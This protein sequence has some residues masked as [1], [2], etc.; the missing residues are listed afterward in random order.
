MVGQALSGSFV[1][2]FSKIMPSPYLTKSD[3]KACFECRTRLFYRKNEYPTSLGENGYIQFLAYG[4]CM[5][6]VVAKPRNT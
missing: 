3:F 1:Y 6:E 2:S 5:I 4:G